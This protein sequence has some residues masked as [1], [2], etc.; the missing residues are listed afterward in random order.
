MPEQEKKSEVV[1]LLKTLWRKTG[2][3]AWAIHDLQSLE[4]RPREGF[5][6]DYF[7][8]DTKL[9]KARA[10][11]SGLSLSEFLATAGSN[12]YLVKQSILPVVVWVEGEDHIRSIGTGFVVSCSGYFI[13]ACH[14]LLDPQESK[15][16]T[17]KK[18]DN[19]IH[20][21]EGIR[22][23]VIL[24]HQKIG[25]PP[26]KVFVPFEGAWY[27]GNWKESPFLDG[28]ESF[29]MATDIAICKLPGFPDGGCYQ[30]LNLSLNEFRKEERAY[31]I[32]YAE[33]KDIPLKRVGNSLI[34]EEFTHDVFVSVG[35]VQNNFPE[36]ATLKEGPTPG[37]CFD[38]QAKVTGKMS[39][40][41]IFGADGAVVRGVVSRSFTDAK[42]AYGAMLEPA[43]KMPLGNAD[44]LDT[45]MKG[46]AEG[47]TKVQGAGL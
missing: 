41:P 25:G 22:M 12:D 8:Y 28:E 29:E 6:N 16:A 38:F 47:M 15:Y 1:A 37:P 32:G 30:P 31:A 35:P 39:V 26:I 17:V 20:A 21:L 40:S 42:H 24:T 23:G 14:V 33:M 46:N 45:L 13:T 18:E 19:G 27:W 7:A 10:G 2:D 4:L 43:L 34:V 5:E 9:T 11:T 36:N 44:T 3:N